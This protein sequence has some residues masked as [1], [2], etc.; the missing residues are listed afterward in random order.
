MSIWTN[1]RL[2]KGPVITT[3]YDAGK[4]LTEILPKMD[5]T[6]GKFETVV[7][8]G[9]FVTD[10]LPETFYVEGKFET[11]MLEGTFVY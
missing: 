1:P 7:E 11:E 4:L 2:S 5:W 6:A 10:T 9:K 3:F 8:L